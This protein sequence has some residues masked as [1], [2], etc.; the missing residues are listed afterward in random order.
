VQAGLAR[1]HTKGVRMPDGRKA[2]DYENHLREVEKAARAAQRGA[3][4]MPRRASSKND[5]K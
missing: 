5:R 1:I 2:N 3:W 4:G